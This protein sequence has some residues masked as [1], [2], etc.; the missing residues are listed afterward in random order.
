M[1]L[2]IGGLD[3]LKTAAI[4]QAVIKMAHDIDVALKD[5]KLSNEEIISVFVGNGLVIAK[6]VKPSLPVDT[7]MSILGQNTQSMQ[8]MQSFVT[9]LPGDL[10]K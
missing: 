6:I 1:G 5:G 10:L 7:V 8:S 9:Q 4:V 3:F 2:N